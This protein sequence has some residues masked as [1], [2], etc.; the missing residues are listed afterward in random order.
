MKIYVLLTLIAVIVGFSHWPS[1][2][3]PIAAWSRR[4]RAKDSA[5]RPGSVPA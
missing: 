3:W 4:G 1:S 2:A 5:P